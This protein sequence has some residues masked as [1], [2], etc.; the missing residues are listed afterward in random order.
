MEKRQTELEKE[1]GKK[2]D[3]NDRRQMGDMTHTQRVKRRH[4][5][6]HPAS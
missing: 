3:A 2:K 5:C 1:T 6:A 4:R